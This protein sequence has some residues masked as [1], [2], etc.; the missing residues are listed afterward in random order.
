MLFASFLLL[1]A[2]TAFLSTPVIAQSKCTSA[3]RL[4]GAELV[5]SAYNLIPASAS[6]ASFAHLPVEDDCHIH[7]YPD[8]GPGIPVAVSS[9]TTIAFADATRQLFSKV[10]GAYTD[11][12]N[13]TTIIHTNV[14]RTPLLRPSSLSLDPSHLFESS[15]KQ[16]DSDLSTTFDAM[17][18]H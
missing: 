6:A 7:I 5:V 1:T 10:T 14:V 2:T 8:G 13:G 3:Q 9:D 17:H 4:A 16:Q 15:S 11:Y 12:E 18:R